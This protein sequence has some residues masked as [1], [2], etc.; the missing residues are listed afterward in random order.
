MRSFSDAVR[1]LRLMI[2]D[3]NPDAGTS[4][5]MLLRLAGHTVVVHQSGFAA[6]EALEEFAPDAMILDLRMPGM[7]GLQLAER[8][9]ASSSWSALPLIAVSANA[10]EDDRQS[11]KVA[12][13]DYH[14]GKPTNAGELLQVLADLGED[15]AAGGGYGTT[16]P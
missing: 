4:L 13:I 7:S 16:K 1:S 5:G 14:F 9:R 15:L 10:R 3:D 2:V 8:V 12:G 6:L 11:S